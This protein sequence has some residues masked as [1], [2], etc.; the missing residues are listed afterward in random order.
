[1]RIMEALKAINDHN[2]NVTRTI[3]IEADLQTKM[4]AQIRDLNRRMQQSVLGPN[5]LANEKMATTLTNRAINLSKAN[6]AP[7][8]A[9]PLP[10]DGTDTP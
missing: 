2:V 4:Y 8:E 3:N 6:P 10:S 5:L 7:K 1:M 9:A